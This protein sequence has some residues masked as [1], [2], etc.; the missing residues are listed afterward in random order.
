MSDMPVIVSPKEG[1]I[2]THTV[3]FLHGRDSTNEEFAKE[4]FESEASVSWAPGQPRT[5]PDLLPSI[6]WVYPAAPILPCARFNMNMSQW[7]DIW[8][9]ENPDEK[10]HELQLD[11]LRSS[12]KT[13]LG[14]IQ[15]EERHLPRS[16]IFLAGISQGF[17]VAIAT[18]FADGARPGLAGLIGMCSWMPLAGMTDAQQGQKH[19][20]RLYNGHDVESVCAKPDGRTPTPI[21]LSHSIDDEVVPVQNGRRLR[22]ILGR[23]PSALEVEWHEYGDGGHWINEPQGVD[24]MVSFLRQHM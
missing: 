21:F 14:V 15:D 1:Q 12:V 11:G 8:S 10:A 5:L 7:F 2:H 24:D 6:K 17:A 16:R 4:L 19:L 23:F 18:F 22:D 9:V 3:I 20:T 13:I